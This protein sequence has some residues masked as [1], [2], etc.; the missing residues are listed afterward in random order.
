MKVTEP[1][2]PQLNRKESPSSETY[3]PSTGKR[4]SPVLY[5]IYW[6]WHRLTCRRCHSWAPLAQHHV[7][8]GK[9][10]S[11]L[12]GYALLMLALSLVVCS[13]GNILGYT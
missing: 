2:I 9:L 4:R 1:K 12:L 6:L 13:T 3:P 5:W 11:A 7:E 10:G 8:T